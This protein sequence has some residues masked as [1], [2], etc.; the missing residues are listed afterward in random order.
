M[1]IKTLNKAYWLTQTSL[2]PT[3]ASEVLLCPKSLFLDTAASEVRL[4]PSSHSIWG[5]AL[6]FAGTARCRIPLVVPRGA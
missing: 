3:K 2:H 4:P 5:E 1:W 6:R